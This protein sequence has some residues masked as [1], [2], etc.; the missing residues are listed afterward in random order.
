MRAPP[1]PQTLPDTAALARARMRCTCALACPN[2]CAYRCHLNSLSHAHKQVKVLLCADGADGG[3]T[4]GYVLSRFLL[5]RQL[6][7]IGVPHAKAVKIALELK[8]RLVD[9]GRLEVSHAEMEACLLEVRFAT[10][11]CA[12]AT[13]LA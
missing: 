4:R 9:E 2:T 3:A 6:T 10:V 8:K 7:A 12:V 11:A 5:C 1:P 13:A